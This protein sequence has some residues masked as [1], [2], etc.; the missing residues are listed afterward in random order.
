[1]ENIF[2]LILIIVATIFILFSAFRESEYKR[3]KRIC[4]RC[5]SDFVV[6]I[7]EVQNELVVK[8]SPGTGYQMYFK[9][10]KCGYNY[11]VTERRDD[12]D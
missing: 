8:D 7:Y 3:N 12:S 6:K 2:I 9:C 1:M 4:P 5:A 11:I 10:N